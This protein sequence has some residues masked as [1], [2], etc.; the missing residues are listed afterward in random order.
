[1]RAGVIGLGD[2][3]SRHATNLIANGFEVTGLD[4]NEWRIVALRE[5][6]G[7]PAE[8]MA[9]VAGRSDAVPASMT[10]GDQAKSAILGEAGFG[11]GTM[12]EKR[13]ISLSLAEELEVP[14]QMESTAMPIF[15]AGQSKCPQGDI[16]ACAHVIEGVVCAGLHWEGTQ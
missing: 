11:I 1:M 13:A 7:A 5:T 14:R 12:H 10:T 2:V 16:W 4:L 3:G 9:E 15:R 6:G 8:S